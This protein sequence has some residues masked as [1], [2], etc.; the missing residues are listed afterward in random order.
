[1]H[2]HDLP[3]PL[4]EKMIYY[5]HPKMNDELKR[6]IKVTACHY[7]LKNIYNKWQN[8]FEQFNMPISWENTLARLL[9]NE[10]QNELIDGL[11]QCGCCNR[12]SRGVFNTPHC[13]TIVGSYTFRKYHLK[14]T[15]Y[16]KRCNCWCR[17]QMRHIL[18]IQSRSK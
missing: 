10:K 8:D 15:W 11:K 4:R 1:M 16:G 14:R 18:N 9:S 7:Y 2:I 3:L 17:L 13:N 6:A 5:A 12:H